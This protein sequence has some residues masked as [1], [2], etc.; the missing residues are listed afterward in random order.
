MYKLR[1]NLIPDGRAVMASLTEADVAPDG[2]EP[3][4]GAA[5]HT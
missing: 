5:V 4:T 3:T 2:Q 1:R